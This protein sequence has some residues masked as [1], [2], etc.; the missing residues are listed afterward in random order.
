MAVVEVLNKILS[1][2][3]YEMR[4]TRYKDMY[5]LRYKMEETLEHLKS[6]GFYP[7]LVIDIGAASGTP[8]FQK[9]F[10]NSHFL[11]VEP[12][13]EFRD[14]L[15]RLTKKYKGEYILG[16]MGKEEG[17]MTLE[18]SKDKVGSSMAKSESVGNPSVSARKVP[19]YTLE[20]IA[21][22]K[23]QGFKQVLL[24]VDV[25]GFELQVL[26][27]AGSYLDQVDV[28]ALEV[29]LFRF[30]ANIPDFYEV[31]HYMKHR[32]F[33]VYDLVEGLNR[34]LDLALGQKDLVFVKENGR[35]RKG[36]NWA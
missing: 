32:G 9:T 30:L 1:R 22:E 15:E 35:F 8:P 16:A 33:V 3:G 23:L 17:E 14:A 12:L 21:R 13:E 29:S 4:N 18:V 28:V 10:P 27:G 26:D 7:D 20:N 31:V 5:I 11:W 6:L 2:I 19:V 24:K 34:P 25:Q 36:H